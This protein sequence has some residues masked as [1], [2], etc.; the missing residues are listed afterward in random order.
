MER[1]IYIIRIVREEQF[2]LNDLSFVIQTSLSASSIIPPR[3]FS[4]GGTKS[5]TRWRSKKSASARSLLVL[6]FQRGLWLIGWKK[7]PTGNICVHDLNCFLFRWCTGPRGRVR[8][9]YISRFKYYHRSYR[10]VAAVYGISA[11]LALLLDINKNSSLSGREELDCFFL[12]QC[13]LPLKIKSLSRH[14]GM[15]YWWYCKSSPW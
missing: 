8:N 14:D 2:G 12:A 9:R 4:S 13:T 5:F 7:Q 3:K 10:Q 6:P 15:F 1:W 11:S